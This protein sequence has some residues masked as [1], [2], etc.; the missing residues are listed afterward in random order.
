VTI[1]WSLTIMLAMFAKQLIITLE[2][3]ITLE[4][5]IPIKLRHQ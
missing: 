2:L 3:Y 1:D 4:S 5:A